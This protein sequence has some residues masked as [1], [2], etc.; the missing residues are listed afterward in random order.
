MYAYIAND[1]GRKI[2]DFLKSDADWTPILFHG[3]DEIRP[4]AQNSYPGSFFADSTQLRN[5]IFDYSQLVEEEPIDAEILHKLS[6]FEST[7]L[8]W[9]EDTTGWNFSF[10]ERRRYYY[11]ILTYWNTVIKKLK[12]DI[13]VAYTWPHLAS[14]YPLY[15]L[16]KHIFNIPVLFLDAYPHFEQCYHAVGSSL[17][18]FS[19]PYMEYYNPSRTEPVS[20]DVADYMSRMRS[21][22][23][24]SPPH[25]TRYYSLLADLS[26]QRWKEFFRVLVLA[27]TGK[28]F[29][30]SGESF[31]KNRKP[32]GTPE[33]FLTIF[34]SFFFWEKLTRQNK[35]L[36]KMYEKLSHFPVPGENYIYFAAP[37]QPESVS[38][39]IPGVY[40]DPF[41]IIEILSA[42]MP[43]NWK[44]YYKEHPNTFKELSK[45][46]LARNEEYYK[47]LNS[48]SKVRIISSEISTF[49]LIDGCRGVA[50]AG[51]TVGWEA[52]VRGKPALLFGTMFYEKCQSV[53]S[54][55]TT[56]DARQALKKIELG[57]TPNSHDVD[58]YAEAILR[59]SEK[60]LITHHRIHDRLKKSDNPSYE[61]KRIATA[62]KRAYQRLY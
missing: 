23:P 38:N 6:K 42:A 52:I 13:F 56:Q 54:I 45:G 30:L 44:I 59:A 25:I 2:V 22:T 24:N 32:M 27:L 21:Q 7:Y 34:E 39:L 46:S 28:A 26:K 47:R 33:A 55:K 20:K 57:Y 15:L 61:M 11:D 35:T 60:G 4:W 5:G 1:E 48:Y 17:E 8:G 12:P 19:A 51:G 41:L 49:N 31:K 3:L 50:T 43:P 10:H 58:S 53:F 36:K 18:D 16:C 14:D 29:K 62:F 37:F 40:E 9:L